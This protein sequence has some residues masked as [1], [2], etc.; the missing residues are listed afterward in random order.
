MCT[1]PPCRLPADFAVFRASY[2]TFEF[3]L[4]TRSLHCLT[5]R[6]M[7]AYDSDHFVELR[8]RGWV[9]QGGHWQSQSWRQGQGGSQGQSQAQGESRQQGDHKIWRQAQGSRCG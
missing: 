8:G 2:C 6:E 3:L 7:E 4:D 9:W 5:D 1:V